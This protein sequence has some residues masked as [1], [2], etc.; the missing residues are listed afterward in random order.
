MSGSCKDCGND[1][2]NPLY[3][4]GE[5]GRCRPCT[6]GRQYIAEDEARDR[7][8][9]ALYNHEPHFASL[10]DGNKQ[11]RPWSSLYASEKAV[12]FDRADAVLTE[13][14]AEQ[15][16]MRWAM[17]RSASRT[18]EAEA[19][20]ALLRSIVK[21]LKSPTWWARLS[22]PDSRYWTDEEQKALRAVLA[23]QE[24]RRDQRRDDD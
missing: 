4:E 14:G 22:Y 17:K 5:D 23:G 13:L 9:L 3:G 1:F 11:K 12:Y 6:L 16:R 20:L 2:D 10:L 24:D 18:A 21:R 19:E 15:Q 8:V 7:L